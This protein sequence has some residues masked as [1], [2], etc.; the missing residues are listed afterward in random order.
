MKKLARCTIAALCAGSLFAASTAQASPR[1]AHGRGDGLGRP[2]GYWQ[3][4]PRR[5]RK[6]AGAVAAGAALGVIGGA[7]IA[8]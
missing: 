2:G 7:I 8:S 4:S 3:Y 6:V 1:H 5:G